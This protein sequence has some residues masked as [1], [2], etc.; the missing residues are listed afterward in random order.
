MKHTEVSK[1]NGKTN[2]LEQPYFRK[3]PYIYERMRCLLWEH[4]GMGQNQ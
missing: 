4:V 2:G 3:R 1:I